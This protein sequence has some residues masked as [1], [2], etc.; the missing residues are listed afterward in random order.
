MAYTK[1]GMNINFENR[2]GPTVKGPGVLA[3]HLLAHVAQV[4]EKVALGSHYY[5]ADGLTAAIPDIMAEAALVSSKFK[6]FID[7]DATGEMLE[8]PETS[9]GGTNWTLDVPGE[10][11]TIAADL[12][13]SVLD[14]TENIV[15]TYGDCYSASGFF[16]WRVSDKVFSDTNLAGFLAD[17]DATVGD[18]LWLQT[19]DGADVTIHRI[20]GVGIN[21]TVQT[22]LPP[23]GEGVVS[24]AYLTGDTGAEAAFGVW[25]AVADG[26]F[27][28]TI[29]GVGHNIDAINFAGDLNMD[30]V[31]ATIQAAVQAATGALETVVW[32]TNHFIITTV[33]SASSAI[34]VTETSTGVVGT[35]ISGAGIADWMDADTGNGTVMDRVVFGNKYKIISIPRYG[36]YNSVDNVFTDAT[37]DFTLL[38][39]YTGYMKLALY[40]HDGTETTG[41]PFDVT[42]NAD[43][44]L[45][46][47]AVPGA[48][49][50]TP[51]YMGYE[52]L[53]SLDGNPYVD[54]YALRGDLDDRRE[55]ITEA[56]L[57]S[58]VGGTQAIQPDNPGVFGAWIATQI[59]DYIWLS[60]PSETNPLAL[61]DNTKCDATDWGDVFSH[62]KTYTNEECAYSYVLMVQNLETISLF[63]L[64]IDYMRE[65]SRHKLCVGWASPPRVSEDVAVAETT[66]PAD[67]VT[68]AD[69]NVI[70]TDPTI[71]FTLYGINVG[72]T[73]EFTDV[74]GANGTAGEIFKMTVTGIA[75]HVLNLLGAEPWAPVNDPDADW[76]YRVINSY[77]NAYEEASYV[78]ALGQGYA[79][80]CFHIAWPANAIR[81]Y[82]GSQWA[83]PT[84][85][86]GAYWSAQLSASDRLSHP[87]TNEEIN[88][89]FDSPSYPS[90]DFKDD[91]ILDIIASGG[92]EIIAQSKAGAPIYSRHQLT[93]DMTNTQTREQSMAYQYDYAALCL[94]ES[95]H[96]KIGNIELD[97]ITIGLLKGNYT[98]IKEHVVGEKKALAGM[99]L[100]SLEKL[101]SDDTWVAMAVNATARAPFNGINLTIYMM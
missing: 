23:D 73:L 14:Q 16:D 10:E 100:I 77:F 29:D 20:I 3:T 58:K 72:A 67:P 28:I 89:L 93:T 35:D 50:D 1:P 52:I 5:S 18:Y 80:R 86:W 4:E 56:N 41:S 31:A 6:V 54:Y 91:A 57:P 46:L 62:L 63:E 26:S 88:G 36:V 42:L 33:D 51:N 48:P 96:K 30:D 75:T 12:L 24:P 87:H 49:P 47:L 32:D 25:A 19:N 17:T 27:R 9:G 82:D 11:V 92:V 13:S 55:Y 101:D 90:I 43:G 71:D 85:Y 2:G 53:L 21:L 60:A 83:L 81:T 98:A 15:K 94:W 61:T 65:P 76:T 66:C 64:F 69:P 39:F 37:Q 68:G 40:D 78:K 8:I 97:D 59:C 95:F 70:F 34:T 79:N 74:D 22:I 84:H 38:P 99:A 7:L 44:E 45:E